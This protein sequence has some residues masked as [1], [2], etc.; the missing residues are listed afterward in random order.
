MGLYGSS[1]PSKST[2]SA[3]LVFRCDRGW[4]KYPRVVARLVRDC[5]RVIRERV[6]LVGFRLELLCMDCVSVSCFSRSR[7]QW[8]S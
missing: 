6:W 4:V 5:V 8:L 1:G 3:S 7:L 2:I